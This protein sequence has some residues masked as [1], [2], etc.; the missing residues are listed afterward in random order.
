TMPMPTPDMSPMRRPTRRMYWDA[1]MVP[2]APP[3]TQQVTASVASAGVGASASPARPLMAISVELLVSSIAWQA[4]S[5]PTLRCVSPPGE[6]LPR[7]LVIYTVSGKEG[8]CRTYDQAARRAF[9]DP[10]T[11]REGGAIA[12]RR[13]LDCR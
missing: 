1:G 5:S 11:L 7:L 10:G 8:H 13:W 2:T 12:F 4:A 9:A 6:L 3:T